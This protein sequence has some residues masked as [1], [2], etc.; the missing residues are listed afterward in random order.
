MSWEKIF[1]LE[2]KSNLIKKKKSVKK[3]TPEHQGNYQFT[4]TTKAFSSFGINFSSHALNTPAL[5][6]V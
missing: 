2:K 5:L 3:V 1:K 4:V 6:H